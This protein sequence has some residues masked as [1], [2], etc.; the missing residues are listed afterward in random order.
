MVLPKVRKNQLL[1]NHR[2]PKIDTHCKNNNTKN[3]ITKTLP[4]VPIYTRIT[5]SSNMNTNEPI[6]YIIKLPSQQKINNRK[7]T[8]INKYYNSLPISTNNNNR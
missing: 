3:R 7:S 5:D 1:S 6:H 2:S 4:Y 8:T